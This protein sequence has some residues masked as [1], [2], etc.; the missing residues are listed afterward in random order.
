MLVFGWPYYGEKNFYLLKVD[1][2]RITLAQTVH[3]I[4][5]HM[6]H[7]P[8]TADQIH[9]FADIQKGVKTSWLMVS[10]N[11]PGCELLHYWL[12]EWTDGQMQ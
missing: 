8:A 12:V 9:L 3:N 10:P 11:Y 6:Y 2:S 1:N 7:F 4:I 5:Y